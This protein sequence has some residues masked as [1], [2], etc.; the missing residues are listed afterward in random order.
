[1]TANPIP[2]LVLPAINTAL[3]PVGLSSTPSN[4]S[5]G[6]AP[7]QAMTPLQQQQAQQAQLMGVP[8][9][10]VQDP[11]V[12][13]ALQAIQQHAKTV[14]PRML[15]LDGTGLVNGSLPPTPPSDA[16]LIGGGSPTVTFTTGIAPVTF[17]VSFPNDIAWIMVSNPNGTAAVDDFNFQDATL[18]GFNVTSSVAGT[19]NSTICYT[20]VGW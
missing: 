9:P 4:I 2:G 11:S 10:T 18:S 13:S 8:G 3:R 17:P 14:S 12:A 16:Y 15:F 6:G 7:Q 20:V 19:G 5:Y 1:M